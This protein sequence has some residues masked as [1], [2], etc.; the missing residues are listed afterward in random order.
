[1]DPHVSGECAIDLAFTGGTERRICFALS[2]MTA[3]VL[4]GMIVLPAWVK[5]SRR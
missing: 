5:N 3:L 4:A 1:M 2:S